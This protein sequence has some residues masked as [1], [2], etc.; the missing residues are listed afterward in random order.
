MSKTLHS[1]QRLCVLIISSDEEPWAT[2][3]FHQKTIFEKLTAGLPVDFYFIHGKKPVKLP[4][5]LR[6]AASMHK[7]LRGISLI[8]GASQLISKFS[9]LRY[10]F[11]GLLAP[12][13]GG[14]TMN[15]SSI[16]WDGP[17][18]YAFIAQKTIA[19]LKAVIE[20][21]NKYSHVLRTNNSSVWNFRALLGY[22]ST[23]GDSRIYA[24]VKGRFGSIEFASGAGILMDIDTATSI[25]YAS[26]NLAY[27]F[28]DDVTIG[29]FIGRDKTASLLAMP[30]QDAPFEDNLEIEAFHFRCKE[31]DKTVENMFRVA[32]LISQEQ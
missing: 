17:E 10:V 27:Q 15:R 1:T 14:A 16:V 18:D 13:P 21:S 11:R 24:G 32:D 20:N 26:H 19:S 23:L 2:W 25:A 12:L 5:R 29:E 28:V 22:I 4:L 3:S 8:P 7:W 31:G 9:F 6:F 30:R